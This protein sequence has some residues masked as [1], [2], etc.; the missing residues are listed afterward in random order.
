MARVWLTLPTFNEVGNLERIVRAALS[1]LERSAPADHRLLVVDD[2]SPD[3]TGVLADHLAAEMPA[4]EVLHRDRKQGLGHAYLA[5]FEHALAGGAELV[6]VMDAD[7]SHDP[8]HLPELLAAAEHADVVLGSRYAAGARVDN[9]PPL[10]RVL[11]RAGSLYARS[12]LHS[13]VRDLTGGFRCIHR[14]VLETVELEALRAQGYVFNIELTF[15]AQQ[16]GFRVAE[17]PIMFQDRSNGES[18]MSLGIA[19]EALWLVPM[20]RFPWLGRACPVRTAPQAHTARPLQPPSSEPSVAARLPP[21]AGSVGGG[22]GTQAAALGA[23][24]PPGGGSTPASA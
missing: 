11:S 12:I 14:K 9:W 1:Q 22:L 24:S 18:K 3:G 20:L 15:R 7:F 2:A 13:D 4:V 21:L 5:G 16:A 17:V 6:I 10:R 8:A 19:V 23:G